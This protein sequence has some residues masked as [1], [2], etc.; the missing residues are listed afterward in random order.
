[1]AP[2]AV[3]LGKPDPLQV[4]DF[5]DEERHDPGEELGA[6]EDVHVRNLPMRCRSC[7]GPIGPFFGA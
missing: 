3:P 1:M 2:A 7:N 6:R 4:E 5:R